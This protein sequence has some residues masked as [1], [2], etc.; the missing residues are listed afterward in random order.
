MS[1]RTRA[2]VAAL[3]LAS[4]ASSAA[5]ARFRTSAS[6]VDMAKSATAFVASL[7][8]EQKTKALM[9]FDS[10]QRIKWH[11]IPL[12]SRKGLQVREMKDD[13]RK[14]AHSLLESCLSKIGYD[15][16]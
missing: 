15:K 4:L 7:S 16:A 12:P 13:Q 6:G 10:D 9:D 5:L 1:I 2:L 11:F 3:I 14:L 8:E